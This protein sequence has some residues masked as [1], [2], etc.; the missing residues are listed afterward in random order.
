[1]KKILGMGNALVDIL[2]ELEHDNLLTTFQL[3][4]GSMQLIDHPQAL[5]I[6]KYT[7]ELPKTLATGGSAS[8]TI[9][10]IR[11]LGTSAGFI[12]KVGKDE[13]G[14]LFYNDIQN[15]GIKPLLIDSNSMTGFATAFVSKDGER[16]FATFLGAAAELTPDDITPEL[17][18]GY[19]IF[20]IEGYL[21]QNHDLITKA[22][23][24][25]KE[26]KIM[27]SLDLAS[28]NVVEDNLDFLQHLV[29]NQ[30]D[31][32]FAN[33]EE[34]KAF[35]G[36]KPVEALQA[37]SSMCE[38]AVVK[39]GAK[40]S[41]IQKGEHS[42]RLEAY[43]ATR[44]DTTGA[45]DIYASGFLHGL[46]KNYSIETCGKLGSFLSSNIISVIG[47]KFSDKE[48]ENLSSDIRNIESKG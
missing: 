2:I 44:R 48:W 21:V 16:T 32:V 24:L 17:F 37:I 36:E 40:G 12:G 10:G 42:Y 8:N 28:Y 29:R 35:T 38:I 25:A 46:A 19:D 18:N 15:S 20:H 7:S 31:I 11:K 26:K 9:H 34:A 43:P 13:K 30:V 14:K 1:M 3:P 47:P 4:K 6:D 41:L 27:V 33:E 23:R 39:I 22:I 5:T 45:G